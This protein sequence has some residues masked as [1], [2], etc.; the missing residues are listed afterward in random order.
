MHRRSTLGYVN[1]RDIRTGD[2]HLSCDVCGRTLLRGERAE[3]FLSGG[4]RKT[5]C[6]L[7]T[8][9]ALNEGWVREGAAPAFDGRES[10]GDR[11][12]SLIAR[13]RARRDAAIAAANGDAGE[14][15]A[16]PSRQRIPDPVGAVRSR[17]GIREPRHVRAV[18]TSGEQRVAAAVDMFNNS[19]HPRTI[20]GV[21]RS[22]GAPTVAVL[23]SPARASV[24]TVTAAWELCWYRYEVDLSDEL[25]S[26]RVA[27]QGYELDELPPEERMPNAIAD[28][29]GGLALA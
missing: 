5:V 25:P 18:P 12:R 21:A 13:L 28:E 26:V 7:C 15:Q 17:S 29:H 27:G 14:V 8:S 22:L 3:P 11:R 16:A 9:R 23:P 6:E 24:V 10:A 19:E 4:A 2:A 20:A 1:T